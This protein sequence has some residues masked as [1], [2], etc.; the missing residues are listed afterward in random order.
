MK[1]LIMRISL[2]IIAI[3]DLKSLGRFTK[4]EQ[5]FTN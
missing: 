1:Q 3:I 4:F 2:N 5:Q